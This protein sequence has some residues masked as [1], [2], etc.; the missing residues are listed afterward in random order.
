MLAYRK[1]LAAILV[2]TCALTAR[3]ADARREIAFPDIPGYQTLMCDFHTHTMFSDGNVWPTLRIDEAWREGLDAIAITDHIEY[4]PHK[5]DVS[6]NLNRPHE[7][8]VERAKQQDI[9]LIRG[10][11]ITHDTPPG[12]FNAI[13]LND[14]TPLNT[15]DL[16]AQVEQ[17]ANQGGFVF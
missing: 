13:F 14:V 2:L 16:Y 5:D 7:L 1:S 8:V 15:P 6:D 11:E 9:L 4:R 12:H 3:A 10:A 17:A